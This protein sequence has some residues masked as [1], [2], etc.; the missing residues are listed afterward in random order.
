V[1]LEAGPLPELTLLEL[2]GQRGWPRRLVALD[3]VEDPQ[4]LGAICRVAD[5]AGVGGLILTRRRAP[6]LSPAVS[7]ASAGALE[8]LPVARVANLGRALNQLKSEGFWVLGADSEGGDDLFLLEDALLSGPLVIVLG[9]EGRGLR[10][11]IRERLDHRVRIPM[12]GRVESLNVSSA[13]AVVL[14]ELVRRGRLP[15]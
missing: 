2:R 14:F 10:R 8:H 4:N 9:A 1:A 6:P 11:G 5:A 3:G 7:R 15:S 12:G 13:A